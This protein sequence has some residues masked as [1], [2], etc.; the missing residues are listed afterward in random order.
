MNRSNAKVL[1]LLEFSTDLFYFIL[2]KR[3]RQQICP[4]IFSRLSNFL[5]ILWICGSLDSIAVMRSTIS[6]NKF[7][8]FSILTQKT[9]SSSNL[10]FILGSILDFHWQQM[11]VVQFYLTVNSASNKDGFPIESSPATSKKFGLK[12]WMEFPLDL[13]IKSSNKRTL[14]T[15][16]LKRF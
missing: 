4:I 13:D 3:W 12:Y 14:F 5:T 15:K 6:S 2:L 10:L 11:L 1:S 7:I 16:K 8:I 9:P